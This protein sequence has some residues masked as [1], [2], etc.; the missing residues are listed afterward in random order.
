MADATAALSGSEKDKHMA[1]TDMVV[2]SA[3]IL[4]VVQCVEVDEA[5]EAEREHL[6][7]IVNYAV[8]VWSAGD[9]MTLTAA[10]VATRGASLRRHPQ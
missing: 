3:A 1:K 7:T 10:A 2:A 6:V 9:I 5:M 4:V 8:N